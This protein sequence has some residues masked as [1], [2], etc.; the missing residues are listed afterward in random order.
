[1]KEHARV[2]EPCLNNRANVAPILG[3]HESQ[4]MFEHLHVH[5]TWIETV[6]SL[7]LFLL[8]PRIRRKAKALVT[9]THGLR[10][11]T[12]SYGSTPHG[13]LLRSQAGRPRPGR[14][15]PVRSWTAPPPSERSPRSGR[16]VNPCWACAHHVG[17][18]R[19]STTGNNITTK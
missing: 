5:D 7:S 1:M 19:K 9:F 17:P 12:R 18:E 2:V 6:L 10:P 13:L 15:D 16:G 11:D 3:G 8:L 4:C 14:W